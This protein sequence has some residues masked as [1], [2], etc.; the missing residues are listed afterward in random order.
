MSRFPTALLPILFLACAGPTSDPEL[1]EAALAAPDPLAGLDER[2]GASEP[3]RDLER[4]ASL[5]GEWEVELESLTPGAGG[6]LL[7]RGEADIQAVLG[8]R[9]LAWDTRFTS[10][11]LESRALLG[12]DGEERRFELSWVSELSSAQRLARGRGDPRR[13]GIELEWSERDPESGGIL[14]VRSTLRIQ[15]ADD[16]ELVQRVLDG[17]TGEWVPVA[18]R[19]Y[20]RRAP[21]R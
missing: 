19:R 5:V 13:A 4:V 15:D 16:F 12:F 14:R 9:F 11:A 10:P 3:G 1:T 18:R 6:E 7:A 20:R 21:A 17:E 8:G 2:R